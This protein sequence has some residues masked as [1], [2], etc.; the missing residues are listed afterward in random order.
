VKSVWT[1]LVVLGLAATAP[2]SFQPV[3]SPARGSGTPLSVAVSGNHLVDGSGQPVR[4]LGVNRSGSEYACVQ[5][6][7]VFDGP[8]DAAS[9]RAI[10]SW[11]V[12]AVRVPLNEDCWL[13]INGVAALYGGRAYQQAIADYVNLLHHSGLYVILDLHVAAHSS[14]V[15]T[16]AEVMPDADHAISFWRQVAQTFRDDGALL[17]DLYS[18]PRDVS[19]DCWRDGV[20]CGVKW[21]V[22]GMQTLV[23]AVRAAGAQQPIILGGIGDGASDLTDW[24]SHE[25]SDPASALIAGIH[26]F[27]GSQ[28][29]SQACWDGTLGAVAQRV[30][31]V[32]TEAGSNGCA[33]RLV[34]SYTSWA[35]AHEISYL[36]WAW[37]TWSTCHSLIAKYNGTP[38]N[39]FGRAYR[40]HLNALFRRVTSAGAGLAAATAPGVGGSVTA[41]RESPGEGTRGVLAPT[42]IGQ[43]SPGGD[44]WDGNS[45]QLVPFLL[46]AL[47]VLSA[48]ATGASLTLA[49]VLLRL[50]QGG[51]LLWNQAPPAREEEEEELADGQDVEFYGPAPPAPGP[52]GKGTNGSSAGD[53][54]SPPS[55]VGEERRRP[56]LRPF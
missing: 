1:A 16:K 23:Q 3:D 52:E 9:V 33:G 36:A 47:A 55:E 38:A 31:V 48:L 26:V 27:S 25:P 4:L 44:P 19:W 46:G 11:H 43:A 39:D 2:D 14:H 32:T 37:T 24:L 50:R 53:R 21:K 28:C 5:G 34:D 56:L 18:A 7:G 51:T 30:P 41:A 15:S 29:S 49:F 20:S 8:S 54:A 13:G 22:A 45:S 40:T 35:D 17:F 6:K 42:L 10:A 12:N